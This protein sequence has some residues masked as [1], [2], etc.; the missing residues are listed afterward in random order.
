M[1]ST[2]R[3]AFLAKVFAVPAGALLAQQAHARG[4]GVLTHYP[5]RLCGNCGFGSKKDNCAKCGKWMA[6]TR[7]PARLC[8]DHGFGSKADNCVTCG[9]WVGSNKQLA[10]VCGNCGFGSKKDNC[11]KCGKWA[12]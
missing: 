3:R 6:S 4:K 2:S 11:V 9:K 8:S 1:S 5:A 7:I 12:P 10:Y